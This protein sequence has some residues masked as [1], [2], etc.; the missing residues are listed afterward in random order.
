MAAI[1]AKPSEPKKQ[2]APDL[3]VLL[4]SKKKIKVICGFLL[5]GG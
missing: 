1:S 3:R 4:A 2:V 5:C